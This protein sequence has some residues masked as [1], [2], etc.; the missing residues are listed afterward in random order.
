MK[1]INEVKQSDPSTW[2]GGMFKR[3]KLI[4][5]YSLKLNKYQDKSVRVTLSSPS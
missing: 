3:F 2:Q 4:S 1:F 5:F